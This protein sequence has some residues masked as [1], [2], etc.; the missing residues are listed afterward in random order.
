VARLEG[1]RNPIHVAVLI[2][3]GIN[4]VENLDLEELPARRLNRYEFAIILDP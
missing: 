4:I 1:T 3:M 2:W